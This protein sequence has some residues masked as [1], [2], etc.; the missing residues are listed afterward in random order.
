MAGTIHFHRLRSP[1]AVDIANEGRT[2]LTNEVDTDSLVLDLLD[3]FSEVY[4]DFTTHR[5]IV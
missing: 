3:T 1:E 2:D 5:L 4:D